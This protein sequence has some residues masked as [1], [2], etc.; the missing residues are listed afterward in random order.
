[1]TSVWISPELASAAR[2]WSMG[3]VRTQAVQPA[4]G[5]LLKRSGGR[6]VR[7]SG[8]LMMEHRGA[9][10]G[11]ERRHTIRLYETVAGT[12]VIEVVLAAGDGEGLPHSAISE[13][14]DLEEAEA[15]LSAYDPA[16]EASAVSGAFLAQAMRLEAEAGRL[17]ADFD[18]CRKAVFAACAT[19]DQEAGSYTRT[20]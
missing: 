17:R 8:M 12:I 19:S 20:N 4:E 9:A 1:M 14:N 7:F 6:P 16:A 11:A 5:F 10:A 2:G 3:R 18:T 15:F 13:V